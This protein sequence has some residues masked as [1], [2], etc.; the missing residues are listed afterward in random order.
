MDNK[1]S[2]FIAL[3][4]GWQWGYAKVKGEMSNEESNYYALKNIIGL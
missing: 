4:V 2:D 1:E 3:F